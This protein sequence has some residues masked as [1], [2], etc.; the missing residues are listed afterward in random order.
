MPVGL[1]GFLD[2]L[3]LV[4]GIIS[5]EFKGNPV[6]TDLTLILSFQEKFLFIF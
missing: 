1:E 3:E 2:G 4:K 6:L 5:L